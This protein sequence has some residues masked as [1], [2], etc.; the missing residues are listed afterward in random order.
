MATKDQTGQLA[1]LT[2][3]RDQSTTNNMALSAH[4]GYLLETQKVAKAGDIMTGYLQLND[5]L[6]LGGTGTYGQTL[7]NSGNTAGRVYFL[8]ND[9]GAVNFPTLNY[10]DQTFS[11]LTVPNSCYLSLGSITSFGIASGTRVV[12]LLIK[13]W[14]TPTPATSL[15]LA[16]GQDGNTLYVITGA[17]CTISSLTVRLWYAENI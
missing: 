7:P 16:L 14:S 2:H 12:S 3:G 4:G 10:K 15:N 11:S 8:K 1:I 13:G 6:I 17:A 5:R 9:T